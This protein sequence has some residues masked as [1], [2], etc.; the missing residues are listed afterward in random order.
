MLE[1]VLNAEEEYQQEGRKQLSTT[2]SITLQ[3]LAHVTWV[4]CHAFFL[5]WKM[6]I[7]PTYDKILSTNGDN[8]LDCGSNFPEKESNK[9]L[10]NEE[11]Y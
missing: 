1:K 8:G 6:E 7:Q 3:D 10:I 11:K 4:S 2:L 5:H 9:T